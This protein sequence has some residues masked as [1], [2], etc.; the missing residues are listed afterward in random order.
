MFNHVVIYHTGKLVWLA[1]G[2]S[3]QLQLYTFKNLYKDALR[4]QS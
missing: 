4:I 2:W 1:Q 3:I